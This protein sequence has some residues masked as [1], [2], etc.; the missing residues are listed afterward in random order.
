MEVGYICLCMSAQYSEPFLT[1]SVKCGTNNICFVHVEC[2]YAIRVVAAIT[3]DPIDHKT[4][5]GDFH[6]KY[7][8]SG[9]CFDIS[10]I[11]TAASQQDSYLTSAVCI[12]A[13]LKSLAG[14]GLIF[15]VYLCPGHEGKKCSVVIMTKRLGCHPAKKRA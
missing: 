9:T 7:N 1:I 5:L 13:M 11:F 2:S 6:K 12:Y 3:V 8:L 14:C 10:L 15:A 4:C